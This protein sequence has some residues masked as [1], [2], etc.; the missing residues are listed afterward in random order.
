MTAKQ[1][2]TFGG[3]M[4]SKFERTSTVQDVYGNSYTKVVVDRNAAR[5]EARLLQSKRD[6]LRNEYVTTMSNAVVLTPAEQ[7]ETGFY[8][9]VY[10]VD[11]DLGTTDESGWTWLTFPEWK[12]VIKATRSMFAAEDAVLAKQLEEAKAVAFGRR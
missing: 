5:S 8:G 4:G 11:G 1:T 2:N 9:R 6:N 3:N 10:G 7:A 12:E